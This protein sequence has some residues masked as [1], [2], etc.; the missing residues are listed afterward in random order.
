MTDNM[1]NQLKA[2][3]RLSAATLMEHAG[4]ALIRYLE[5]EILQNGKTITDEEISRLCRSYSE[6]LDTG[7]DLLLKTFESQLLERCHELECRAV[8]LE[9]ACQKLESRYRNSVE[10]TAQHHLT[11]RVASDRAV[12]DT[13][14]QSCDGVRSDKERHQAQSQT[15]SS[16]PSGPEK[17]PGPS[18]NQSL[19]GASD[20]AE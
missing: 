7:F 6:A 18:L 1:I 12:S 17:S 20:A 9:V 14:S 2:S 8:N 19:R 16:N 11:E 3:P 13:A 15:L 5:K 4:I 10:I